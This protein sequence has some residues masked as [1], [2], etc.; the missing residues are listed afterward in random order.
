MKNLQWHAE[1][2]WGE[3]TIQKVHDV[4]DLA[5]AKEEVAKVR[6]SQSDSSI[7]AMFS[8]VEGKG[9]VMYSYHQHI[10]TKT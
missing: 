10:S 4:K 6:K 8:W 9:K 1:I 3:E 5:V 2:C 7:T